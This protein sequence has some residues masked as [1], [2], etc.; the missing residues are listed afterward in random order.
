MAVYSIYSEAPQHPISTH[1]HRHHIPDY[2]M[3]AYP[4]QRPVFGRHPYGKGHADHRFYRRGVPNVAFS[5]V[6]RSNDQLHS[7]LVQVGYMGLGI[8]CGVA[9]IIC[10]ISLKVWWIKR[11]GQKEAAKARREAV[12]LWEVEVGQGELQRADSKMGDAKEIKPR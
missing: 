4:Y 10:T 7:D 9:L 5:G 11:K 8:V 12:E 2:D 3:S 1:D 6:A